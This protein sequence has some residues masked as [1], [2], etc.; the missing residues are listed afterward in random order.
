MTVRTAATSPSGNPGSRFQPLPTG[1]VRPGNSRHK[2]TEGCSGLERGKTCPRTKTTMLRSKE[3]QAMTRW[4]AESRTPVGGLVERQPEPFRPHR[5]RETPPTSGLR[6]ETKCYSKAEYYP[7]RQRRTPEAESSG[8]WE[9][10]DG[11]E[12]RRN[13]GAPRPPSRWPWPGHPL[14]TSTGRQLGHS[15]PFG[16]RAHSSAVSLIFGA[17]RKRPL[18]QP[19]ATPKCKVREQA[20]DHSRFPP[21]QQRGATE[22][23]LSLVTQESGT[24]PDTGWVIRS[25]WSLLPS[26]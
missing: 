9:T 11:S 6:K 24:Q 16:D 4:E 17:L 5:P 26:P 15:G 23:L 13:R 25:H 1:S 14:E 3:R 22:P 8:S 7:G 18:L 20:V 10:R 19:T 21:S 2:T 12:V